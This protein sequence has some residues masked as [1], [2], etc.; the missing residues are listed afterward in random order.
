MKSMQDNLSLIEAEGA[1][2]G[3]LVTVKINGG[4]DIKNIDLD[5]LPP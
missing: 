2:G 4:G 5:R 3:G 1:S